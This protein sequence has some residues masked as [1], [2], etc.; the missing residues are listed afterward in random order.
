MKLFR[1]SGGTEGFV[2]TVFALVGD[3]AVSLGIMVL[4]HIRSAQ[5]TWRSCRCCYCNGLG[6][7]GFS[8][9]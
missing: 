5:K 6:N 9:V 1:F 2:P 3:R 8:T 7:C 4:G